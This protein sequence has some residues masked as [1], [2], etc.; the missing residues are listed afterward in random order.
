ME[1]LDLSKVD[2]LSSHEEISDFFKISPHRQLSQ[3]A[4]VGRSNAGKSSLINHLFNNKKLARVS[5]TPGK[6]KL[7]NFFKAKDR[8]FVD[9][10]GYGYAKTMQSMRKQWGETI[11]RFFTENT[12]L[13]CILFLLDIRRDPN[14]DDLVMHEWIVNKNIPCIYILTKSDKLSPKESSKRED[15]IS[16]ILSPEK[17]LSFVRYSVFSKHGRDHLIKLLKD[18]WA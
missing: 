9:L 2:F 13:E 17:S 10:P 16:K 6:T 15:E 1:K 18:K 12:K 8:L 7:L 3:I 5:K 14:E 11:E 4:L